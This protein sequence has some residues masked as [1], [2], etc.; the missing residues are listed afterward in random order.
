MIEVPTKYS[1]GGGEKQKAVNEL[2]ISNYQL[3]MR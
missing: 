1:V 2:L 3:K